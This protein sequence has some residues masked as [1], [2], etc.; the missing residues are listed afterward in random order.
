MV[1][2]TTNYALRI[3]INTRIALDKLFVDAVTGRVAGRAAL[4]RLFHA[5]YIDNRPQWL[6]DAHCWSV[7]SR[8][9]QTHVNLTP[10][11][12]DQVLTLAIAHDVQIKYAARNNAPS[13]VYLL[14]T[15]LEAVVQ[16]YLVPVP[17]PRKEP[18]TAEP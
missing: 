16:G 3:S 8:L 4:A 1:K 13:P 7:S 5:N 18:P 12:V 2:G 15:F 11:Q 14:S 10:E 6:R 9:V 17:P